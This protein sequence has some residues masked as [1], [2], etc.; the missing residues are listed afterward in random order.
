[1]KKLAVIIALILSV[2]I[3]TAQTKNTGKATISIP[4]IQKD[5]E[6]CATQ[7]ENFIKREVGVTSVEV[8]PYRKIIKITWV[9]DRTD[10]DNIKF[11]IAQ[12]GYKA[13]D[14]EADEIG[15]KK[16]PTCCKIKTK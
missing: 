16:L 9:P 7:L 12:R 14:V 8:N 5:C 11:A 6:E 4:G 2:Q 3:V 15:Y 13:D 1:M 10:I